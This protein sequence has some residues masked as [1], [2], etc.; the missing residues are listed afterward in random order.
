MIDAAWALLVGALVAL[1]VSIAASALLVVIG[2]VRAVRV[3]LAGDGV[4]GP[5]TVEARDPLA[6]VH[7]GMIVALAL[8]LASLALRTVAVG[9]APWSNLHEFSASFAG[10]LL[11]AYVVLERGLPLRRLAPVVAAVAAGLL[12][13]AL[14]LD[15]RADPLVPALQQPFLLTVH[16]GSA[17]LAYAVSAIAFAAAIG[18]LVQRRAG[19]AIRLLPSA[20]ACR[21]AAHRCILIAFPILTLTIALGAVWANLAWRSPWSN[22][23]KELAAAATWLV[24]GAYLHVAGRRD[25][26]A[27]LAPWLLLLGFAGV[28][29]TYVGASLWFVGE[30]SYAAP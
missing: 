18:E 21:D 25:R 29:F 30:H 15:N 22:D 20:A 4:D 3:A 10:V 7:P 2:G 26:L 16:V 19:D 13:F 12:A 24:Y 1:L 27:L 8:A 9:H 11:A 6:P 5:T 14:T 17:V 23:P 28:L